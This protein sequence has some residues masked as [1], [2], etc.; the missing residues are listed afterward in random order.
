MTQVTALSDRQRAYLRQ[1]LA[2]RRGSIQARGREAA[3]V[4][5]QARGIA[6]RDRAIRQEK[7]M[8]ASL[9]TQLSDLEEV[10]T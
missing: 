4:P 6:V 2:E 1:L 9:L 7:Q 3:R 5:L 10:Q 8:I